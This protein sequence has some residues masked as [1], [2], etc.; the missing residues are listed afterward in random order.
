MQYT[1]FF[2]GILRNHGSLN[3]EPDQLRLIMN[4]IHLE[5]KRE[6]LLNVQERFKKTD[7]PNR[8]DLM[9]KSITDQINDITGGS[10]PSELIQKWKHEMD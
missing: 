4:L 3:F 9:I 6:G 7:P 10:T 2:S 8:Y 5:G 1:K